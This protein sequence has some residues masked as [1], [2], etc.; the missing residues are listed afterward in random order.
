[1]KKYA[2]IFV[3]LLLVTPASSVLAQT[4]GAAPNAKSNGAS[5]ATSTIAA[6]PAITDK[7][8]PVELARA[9]LAAL[10]GDKFKNLK[11][12]MLVGDAT[13]YAPNSTQSV[14]GKFVMVTAGDKVRI[15]IDASPIFK[16]KQVFDGRQ[17]LSSIP[18]LE[19]PPASRFGMPVLAKYDQP[20]YTVSALPDKKKLRGFRIV[21]SDGNTTDFF[22]DP[23]SGRVMQY[24]IPYN[25]V[26][27]GT[28]NS[29]FMEVEGV[30]IPSS[31]SQRLETQLGAYFAEYKVKNV[32]LNQ[33]I[34]DDVFV[35]Q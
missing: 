11:S 26:T 13:L 15:D 30:L 1:M 14:P 5:A 25:G 34:G 21:D 22:I 35:I 10:G 20:G 31:F 12:M 28:E 24:I 16:F 2:V 18:G 23:A 29:K 3:L 9:A 27:F 33:P 6:P 8:T 17:S 19:M 32:K 4:P 7:S